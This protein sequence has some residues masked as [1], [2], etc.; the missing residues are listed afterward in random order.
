MTLI[1]LV[2]WDVTLFSKSFIATRR[3]EGTSDL[4]MGLANLED[5]GATVLRNVWTL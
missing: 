3:F 4:A 2:F 1:I 5:E